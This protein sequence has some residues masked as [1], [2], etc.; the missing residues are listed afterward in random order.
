MERRQ[1]ILLVDDNLVD[2]AVGTNI[3]KVRYDVYQ[4][5]SAQSLY[6][7]LSNIIP[8]L[9]L[10]DVDMPKIGGFEI[11]RFMK[12]DPRFSALPFLF[13]APPGDEKAEIE[14]LSL[15]ALDFIEKPFSAPRLIKR[16]E[17]S[18]IINSQRNELKNHN[19][20]MQDMVRRKTSRF[21]DIQNSVL[22]AI[23]EMVEIRDYST[24]GHVARTRKYLELLLEKM[25]EENVYQEEISTWDFDIIYPS[26]QLHDVGKIAISDLILNKPSRLSIDEFAEIKRHPQVGVE[27]LRKIDSE[28]A[29]GDFMRHA[30][31]FA[32]THHERWDGAGYP[33][34]LRGYEIPLEGRLMAIADV[35]DALISNKP[36]KRPFSCAE[37][38][39]IISN[40]SGSQFDPTLVDVFKKV[41]TQF[42]KVV[43]TYK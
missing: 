36:Y 31:V 37:A 40:G 32:G 6:E 11:A 21:I 8:D 26:A 39:R 4:A 1:K 9:I 10:L 13:M 14:G 28:M 42:A 27:A 41:A 43:S 29:H 18:L 7:I 16:V 35:Y 2:L 23:A 34:G 22:S 25:A 38:E 15:G 33:D 3:L 5:Q 12:S 30:L 19:I 24:G 17:N 20:N